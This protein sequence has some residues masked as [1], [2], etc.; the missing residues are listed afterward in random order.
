MIFFLWGAYSFKRRPAPFSA[1]VASALCVLLTNPLQLWNPGFQLSYSVVTGILLYGLPLA[2]FFKE[3]L[4][5]ESFIPISETPHWKRA[6]TW[7]KTKLLESSAITLSATLLS[8]PLVLGYFQ[9]FSPGAFLLNLI[10]IPLASLTITLGFVSLICGLLFIPVM[11][12]LFNQLASF[13]IIGLT[14]SVSWGLKT[15]YIFWE[16]YSRSTLLT[17]TGILGLLVLLICTRPCMLKNRFFRLLAPLLFAALW[18]IITINPASLQM[19]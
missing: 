11:P 14:N 6:T 7:T 15:P 9:M 5:T 10:L 16:A 1:L 17:L 4:F 3:R 12:V 2:A 19:L 18:T 8:T 13:C